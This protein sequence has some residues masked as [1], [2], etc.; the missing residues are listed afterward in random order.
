MT[1]ADR[2]RTR[3]KH[4]ID[5]NQVYGLTAAAT[6]ALRRNSQQPGEKGKLKTE[7]APTGEWA[8][9][10]YDQAGNR[11]PDFVS[12]PD[13]V[14]L[15]GDWPPQRKATLFAFGGERANSTAL[16]AA[17]NTLFLREHNRLCTMLERNNPG[18]DDERVFQT[19]RNINIVQLIKVVVEEYINHISPY[20]FRL[21][22][23]PTP[24]Y[25]AAWNRENWIPA[26]FNL[27]YRWHSL[28]PDRALWGGST[29][30]MAALR[31]DNTPLLADGLVTALESASRSKAWQIGLFNTVPMLEP[32]ERASIQQGRDNQLARYNDYRAAM[33]YPRVTRF[34]QINGDPLVAAELRRIYGD[35]D[36]IEYFV[37]L[38]AEELPQRSAV[39]SLIGRMVAA[40]AFSHALTNPLL[41]PHVFNEATF[42]AEGMHTIEKTATLHDILA[43][44]DNLGPDAFISMEQKGYDSVA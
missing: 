18:W 16:T 31:F 41:S 19:A 38:F 37:G 12:V 43:R 13:P 30:D 39:P 14:H 2:R 28:V 7:T 36:K 4:Q 1:D 6:A 29:I 11:N 10:L 8:P 22:A 17:V 20:W 15:P 25:K 9:R 34:E 33:N 32:V 27:L 21:L 44:N 5:L 35:V 24:C 26:E 40:D 23:D 3:T 42:T